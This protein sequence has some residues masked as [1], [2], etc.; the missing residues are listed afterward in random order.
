SRS[1]R[2]LG[3]VLS[4]RQSAGRTRPRPLQGVERHR[5]VV[6][7]RLRLLRPPRS[8]PR[9]QGPS[10]PGH[11]SYE[12][13][14]PSSSLQA[15]LARAATALERGRGVEAAQMLAPALKSTLPRDDE[16]A[17]R[18]MLAEAWLRQD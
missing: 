4:S 14:M 1:A 16:L 3:R 5:A 2:V 15:L 6:V 11:S 12:A 7:R 8:P 10:V 13:V 9:H 17:L 18:G